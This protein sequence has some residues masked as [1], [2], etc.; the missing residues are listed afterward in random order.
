M[1]PMSD[2]TSLRVVCPHC[3]APLRAKAEVAGKTGVCPKCQRP[4]VFTGPSAA[5]PSVA[6]EIAKLH[7]LLTAGAITPDEYERAKAS[8]L[9]TTA[10]G[11]GAT[12]EVPHPWKPQ[13]SKARPS[14]AGSDEEPEAEELP[15]EAPDALR[16][17]GNAVCWLVLPA[18]MLGCWWFTYFLWDAMLYGW[19]GPGSR[20]YPGGRHNNWVALM[21]AI[22]LAAFVGLVVTAARSTHGF[23]IAVGFIIATG[24]SALAAWYGITH[25]GPEPLSNELFG[26]VESTPPWYRIVMAAALALPA[27]VTFSL[28]TRNVNRR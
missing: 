16:I 20:A 5:A 15:E 18:V 28:V 12:T 7:A 13:R 25:V 23:S 17:A 24:F 27:L 26:R 6:D 3:S 11:T 22:Y 10:P 19:S 4:V 21:A 1:T 2:P 14:T 9:G 8:L